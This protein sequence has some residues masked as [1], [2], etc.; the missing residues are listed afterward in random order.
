MAIPKTTGS[1]ISSRFCLIRLPTGNV[2]PTLSPTSWVAQLITKGMV[3]RVMMLLRAVR[4]TDR[5]TSPPASL[6]NTFDELPPGQQ[7][8]STKPMKK[9]GDKWSSDANSKAMS[10]NNTS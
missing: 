4:V 3:K 8:M 10:G 9:T 2:I 5:A 6:E 1:N 7:A